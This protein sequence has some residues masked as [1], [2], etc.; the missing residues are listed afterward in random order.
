MKKKGKS[1]K[2][3]NV[4]EDVS[5]SDDS[6]FVIRARA[7]SRTPSNTVTVQRSGCDVD[8]TVDSCAT[9]NIIGLNSRSV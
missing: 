3:H 9:C 7:S 6:A 4:T 5:D 8:F 2:L 1:G